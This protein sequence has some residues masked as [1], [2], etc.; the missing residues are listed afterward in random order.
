MWEFLA[1]ARA[2]MASIFRTE[3]TVSEMAQMFTE[4]SAKVDK[5]ITEVGNMSPEMDAEDLAAK[6]A[7]ADKLQALDDLNPDAP[8]PAEG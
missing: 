3:H 5:I 4:M 2:A 6:Q 7:L 1:T 8:A